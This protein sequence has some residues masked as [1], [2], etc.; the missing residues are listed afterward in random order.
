MEK[1]EV[2]PNGRF[3]DFR[4]DPSLNSLQLDHMKGKINLYAPVET[5]TEQW[6]HKGDTWYPIEGTREQATLPPV[7]IQWKDDYRKR[8]DNLGNPK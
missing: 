7:Y 8:N 4:T 1:D 2:K 5:Y 3:Y 6:H